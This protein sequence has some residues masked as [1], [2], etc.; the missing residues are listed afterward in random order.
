MPQVNGFPGAVHKK[1]KT[2]REAEGFLVPRDTYYGF[3]VGAFKAIVIHRYIIIPFCQK[4]VSG[5]N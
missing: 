4:K 2:I 3:S 5:S 1:F